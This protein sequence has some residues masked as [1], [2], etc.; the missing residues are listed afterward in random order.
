MN[1]T[2]TRVSVSL[3]E[4]TKYSD[5]KRTEIDAPAEWNF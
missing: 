3:G 1:L 2:T 4:K 5:W